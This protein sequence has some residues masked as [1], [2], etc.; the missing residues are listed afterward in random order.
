MTDIYEL[1]DREDQQ[2]LIPVPRWALQEVFDLAQANVMRTPTRNP[3]RRSDIARAFQA[4]RDA[5][6]DQ[7]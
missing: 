5:M 7:P 4:F 6:G 1:A 2:K 3:R